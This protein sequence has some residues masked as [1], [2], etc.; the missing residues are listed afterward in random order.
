MT[1]YAIGDIQG[2]FDPLQALLKKIHFSPDK[3]QLWFTG[4][5][6][7]RG[8]DSLKVLAFVKSLGDNAITVLGNHDLHMLA[9]LTD[10]EQPRSKDTLDEVYHSPLKT[11]YIDWVRQLPLMHVDE[12]GKWA[13]VH[14]GCYPSWSIS[15]AR[16]Y[17]REAETVLQGD[18][19]LNF[20]RNMYGNKPDKWSDNL[21]GWDRIRF[22]TNCF[23][24]MRYVYP[25]LSLDMKCKGG[26]EQAPPGLSPW[27][28]F[29]TE[30][31]A[32]YKV[33]FG[34][35]STLG[36]RQQQGIFALDT[37]CLWGG[38]LTA[39]ALEDTPHTISTDCRQMLAPG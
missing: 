2:C 13:L 27:Y 26:P 22:I 36:L 14:A 3:D 25:N 8:P 34:H 17:A 38:K 5:L 16:Q 6:V 21:T 39:L 4:D 11:R 1:T 32:P 35:W 24:R 20:L 37:G 31:R 29:G 15:Q 7:N 10:I 19:Y 28:C 33:I 18:N 23:T 12:T 30:L 9:V